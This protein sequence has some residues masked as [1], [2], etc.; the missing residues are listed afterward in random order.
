[1]TYKV[2]DD[3]KQALFSILFMSYESTLVNERIVEFLGWTVESLSA[4]VAEN[5]YGKQWPQGTGQYF[6]ELYAYSVGGMDGHPASWHMINAIKLDL[7]HVKMT[8]NGYINTTFL[9]VVNEF[10]LEP[11]L[12][13]AGAASSGK[14]FPI[15]VCMLE[16]WKASP[17]N[18]LTF[19]CTTSLGASEDRIWGAIVGLFNKG[20][21]KC[22][23]HIAHKY[24]IAWDNL[25][26]DASDREYNAAIKAV[27]IPPG[28]EGKKAIDTLR[29][30]KN[31]RV[32]LVFDELPEMG[33]YATNAAVNLESNSGENELRVIY[34]GNPHRH[35]D[36][37]GAVCRPDD[38]RGYKAINKTTEKWKTRTGAAIFMN[39]EWSPNF[40]APPDEPIPFP[41]LTNRKVLAKMLKRCHGNR[42]SIEYYRNA[43][44]FWPDSSVSETVLT[45]DIIL[46]YGAN[47]RKK[48][49]T[50]EKTRVG[51]LDVGFGRGG[52]LCVL[53]I[54]DFGVTVDNRRVLQHTKEHIIMPPAT[55]VFEEEVAK[56]V[57]DICRMENVAPDN[58]G[59]DISSDGGKIYREIVRYWLALG[60]KRAANV[61]AISSMGRPSE[62]IVSNVDPRKCS[63]AFD[64]QVTEYWM[65][66]REGVMTKCIMGIPLVEGE[67]CEL[68]EELC[69]RLYEIKAKK[70]SIETKPDMKTRLKRSPDRADAF[71]YMVEM[72]RRIGLAFLS[73]DDVERR[74][75]RKR[76]REEKK[77]SEA[78]SGY[79]EDDWGEGDEEAA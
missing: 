17:S 58:L 59:M 46:A 63:E 37:H 21:F 30:R 33:L 44:G 15:A 55:G 13:I 76:Q 32:R 14:T 56:Q 71:A 9:R 31:K 36:A 42:D 19:V 50:N 65:M 20:V 57:V 18:T 51:G 22:G 34:I 77:S 27:A 16:D 35:D 29:G 43:I 69:A 25:S 1:L 24:V 73:P 78:F 26:D 4:P 47:L 70:F 7:P 75:E 6:K 54:G 40:Q 11:D 38:P 60:N 8:N 2:S 66:I 64:R 39:G 53:Q 72:A 61:V 41:Y 48:W 62:R 28:E 12:A 79:E 67:V 3:N 49:K 45:T 52:D 10:C 74:D 5:D 68:V 23:A